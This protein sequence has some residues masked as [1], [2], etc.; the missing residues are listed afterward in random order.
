M[1]SGVGTVYVARAERIS[2]LGGRWVEG[3]CGVNLESWRSRSV[4]SIRSS[5]ELS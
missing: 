3:V 4:S 2:F 5:I 1:L